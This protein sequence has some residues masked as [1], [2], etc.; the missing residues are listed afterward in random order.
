MMKRCR[1]AGRIPAAL[2]LIVL[3]FVALPVLGK[4]KSKPDTKNAQLTFGIQM[5][6]RGLWS[7]AL[8]RFQQAE[9]LEPGNARVLNNMAVAYEALGQ[10]DVA[11]D[12][13]QRAIKAAP[14]NADMKRNYSR[15][16]EFY[17]A[18]KA[19]GGDEEDDEED[20][21]EDAD[22]GSGGP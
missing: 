9:R 15:F 12:Y 7:E 19:Q 3:G 11:L 17:R 8:F 5:A 6:R 21:E 20:A 10:F 18:F 4:G 22:A 1:H 2:I 16:V 13:Y 14:S